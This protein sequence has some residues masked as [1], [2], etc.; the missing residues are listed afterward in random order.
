[1]LNGGVNIQ[2][3]RA[4]LQPAVRSIA[5]KI[6]FELSKLSFQ[7]CHGP[8]KSSIEVLSS[9]GADQ[10]FNEGMRQRNVR[11]S[12]NFEYLQHPQIGLPLVE[13]IQGIMIGTEVLRQGVPSNH[14]I[15]HAAQRRTINDAAVNAEPDNPARKLVHYDQNPMRSQRNRL[16]SK[17]IETPQ[18]VLGMPE[19]SEPG[20]TC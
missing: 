11:D 4:S 5:I 13:S 16:A 3:W 10:S 12:L 7:I 1:M 6:V 19:K 9:Y 20:R 2:F 14:T 15:E 8:E 17:Q 18:T